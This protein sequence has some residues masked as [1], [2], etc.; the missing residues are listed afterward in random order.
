MGLLALALIAEP[1]TATAQEELVVPNANANSVTVYA[2]TASGN[3]APLRTL[4]G[5]ATELGGPVGAALDLV[6][7]ELVVANLS[8]S[9]VTVYART[10]SGNIAPLRRLPQASGVNFPQ[11]V[12]LDLVHDELVV[13]N[14]GNNSVTVHA[15]TASGVTPILRGIQG[16]TTGLNTPIGVALDLVHDEL[17][18]ANF[19]G[20]AVT[21]YARTANGNITPLRSLSGT[22]T[23]LNGPKGVALDLVNDELLVANS[24][25]N[26]VRVYARTASGNTAPLRALSGTATGVNFPAGLALDLVHDELLVGNIN[27]NSVTVYARTAS[28]DTAPLRTLAGASTGLNAPNFP[29]PSTSPPLAAAVLPLSRSH[30]FGSLL[31]AF[32]TIINAGPGPVQQ[33]RVGPPAS[34]PAGL[35][36]F[37]FQTTDPTTNLPT[38]TLNRPANI[39][40]GDFQTFVFGVT[41]SGVIAETSVALE[42]GCENTVGAPKITGVNNLILVTDAN[43]VPDTIALMS[44]IGGDGIVH[45]PGS[46]GTQLFAIGTSNVGAT[47]TITVSG[48]TGANSLP[49]TLLVCETNPGTGECLPT[50]PPASSVTVTYGANTSRSFKFFA[51]ASGS[52]AFSPGANRVFARLKQS[53][54]TR[55]ATSAA[56][57]TTPNAG[58]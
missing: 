7:D 53:G 23:G 1:R 32:A 33:C 12:A 16:G 55:G 11:G 38:G 24:G 10:A 4:S 6:H 48:D 56:V 43:P 41:P 20:N 9:S 51:Q 31:T 42:F 22:A 36:P 44:T 28:G 27:A 34:P 15:R 37:I 14:S 21:V 26:S 13:A 5:T 3:V 45:I 30:Q 17:V 39:A 52:I 18:V 47:G 2:R 40:A 19:G 46:T 29:T 54:V 57:C 8:N 35:G 49:L 25:D 50:S 58:C